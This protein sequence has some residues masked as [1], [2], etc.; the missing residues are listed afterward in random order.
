MKFDAARALT[1]RG[2]RR[3]GPAAA[4]SR[5]AL[6]AAPHDH[7][8]RED[9]TDADGGRAG[10]RATADP[11]DRA[12]TGPGGG[13]GRARAGAYAVTGPPAGGD[14]PGAT[15][16]GAPSSAVTIATWTSPG[17]AID[18]AQDVGGQQQD[19]AEQHRDRAGRGGSRCRPGRG[20]RAGWSA[21]RSRP[22]RR[23][24]CAEPQSS[25]TATAV[26]TRIRPTRAPRPRATSSPRARVLR[27]RP[28][29]RASSPPTTRKGSTCDDDAE[30]AAAQ[31]ADLPEAEL[32]E[33]LLVGQ[34]QR[35]G[36]GAEEGGDARPRRGPA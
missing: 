27:P 6:S 34:Q 31:A 4:G 32:V 7:D 28:R 17:R 14:G 2:W 10:P 15:K 35:G 22:G 19:R 9:Q 21:R 30:V 23:P 25:T 29:P 33:G 36:E 8:E 13:T 5:P 3:A 20:R 26:P 11:A 18:P 24:R 16:T 12:D 1:R